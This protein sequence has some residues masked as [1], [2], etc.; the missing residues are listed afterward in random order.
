MQDGGIVK[1]P[2]KNGAS[3]L[4]DDC[5]PCGPPPCYIPKK[6]F[7]V[8]GLTGEVHI[9]TNWTKEELRKAVDQIIKCLGL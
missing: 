2:L 3:G 7:R 4:L 8:R 5:N 6:E 9:K 1:F